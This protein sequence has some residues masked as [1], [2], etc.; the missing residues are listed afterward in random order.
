MKHRSIVDDLSGFLFFPARYAMP[1]TEAL[2]Q[3]LLRKGYVIHGR[4]AL[5]LICCIAHGLIFG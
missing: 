3:H 1:Y 4:T 2:A 5:S